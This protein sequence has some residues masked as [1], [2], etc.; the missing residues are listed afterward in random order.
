MEALIG[1]I[2]GEEQ[3]LEDYNKLKNNFPISFI[4]FNQIE[5][6]FD[7][8]FYTKRGMEGN[9][10]KRYPLMHT[11]FRNLEIRSAEVLL[12]S[13]MTKDTN[14]LEV[15]YGLGY[16]AQAFTDLGVQ[17]YTC[18]ELNDQL[19]YDAQIFAENYKGETAIQI[20]QGDYIDLLN[21]GALIDFYDIIYYSPSPDDIG[22]MFMFNAF[23][24]VSKENTILSVQGIP[25]FSEFRES[26]FK[27]FSINDSVSPPN[28][29][30]FDNM[31]TES[32]YGALNSIG[33]FKVYYQYYDG[34]E[35]LAK[36][37]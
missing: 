23:K 14:V 20:L 16:S 3:R 21:K 32:L 19:Y 13:K 6:Y 10:E 31:F 1:E 4:Q 22:N 27:N 26:E 17:N 2:I 35:W 8:A 34:K 9:I 18:I 37:I 33:Y 25:L 28:E 24:K 15:G 7:K 11:G 36:P 29:W 30:E 5:R 12:S